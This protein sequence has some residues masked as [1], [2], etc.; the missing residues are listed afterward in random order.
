MDFVSPF[1]SPTPTQVSFYTSVKASAK[2]RGFLP[3]GAECRNLS[4]LR[5]LVK[6][7]SVTWR[8]CQNTGLFSVL[9]HEITSSNLMSRYLRLKTPVHYVCFTKDS[10]QVCYAFSIA[11]LT[12]WTLTRNKKAREKPRASSLE[13]S[14]IH[15]LAEGWPS[16]Q[17]PP[18]SPRQSAMCILSSFLF[19]SAVSTAHS[20]GLYSRDRHCLRPALIR[21][22]YHW[23]GQRSTVSNYHRTLL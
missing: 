11:F 4:A 22:T 10:C 12:T 18:A 5:S 8:C 13:L 16:H 7:N 6:L 23:E 21:C 9:N 15:T 1:E 2:G 3:H 17:P 14:S 20:P 19:G